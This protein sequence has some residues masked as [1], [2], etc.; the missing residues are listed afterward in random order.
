MMAAGMAVPLHP[1]RPNRFNPIHDDD[2]LATMPGLLAAASVPVTTVNWGGPASSIEEW[3]AEIGR[4]V[5]LEPQFVETEQTIS[6][7]VC[8]HQPHGRP[9]RGAQGL[10]V[11]GDGPHGGRPAPDLLKS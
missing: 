1:E 7:V 11:R 8:R 5:G 4:P 10:H 9:D 3:C 6:S 2:I